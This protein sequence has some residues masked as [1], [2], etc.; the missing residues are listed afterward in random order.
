MRGMRILF[1]GVVLLAPAHAKR[2]LADAEALA[3][4]FPEATAFTAEE[5]TLSAEA[6]RDAARRLGSPVPEGPWTVHTAKKEN[7]TLGWAFFV[8]EIGKTMP[9]TLLVGVSADGR[10]AGV[11]LVEFRES[12]GDGIARTSFREQFKGKTLAD[13]LKISR[14]IRSVTSST[15][16]AE[17]T[18]LAVRK[19]LVLAEALRLNA[20]SQAGGSREYKKTAYQM[21][22]DVEVMLVTDDPAKA[23]FLF[24]QAFGIFTRVESQASHFL[25]ESDL[26]RLN[27]Q[28]GPW[29]TFPPTGRHAVPECLE[30]ARRWSEKTAG[31]FDVTAAPL[32]A[33]WGFGAWPGENRVPSEEEIRLALSHVGWEKVELRTEP[34]SQLHAPPWQA[35][36]PPGTQITLGGI[37]AG[38]AIDRVVEEFRARGVAQAVVNAGGDLYVL[39]GPVQEEAAWIG[40]RHPR[41]KSKLA[42]AV[43]LR[44][45]AIA[46]SGDAEKFFEADGKRYSHILDPRTG[47]PVPWQ[48]SVTVVAP[49][50][51]DADALS[52]ALYVLGPQQGTALVDALGPDYA[53]IFLEAR[54]DGTLHPSLTARMKPLY[55]EKN[56]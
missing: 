27:R 10:V 39:S 45:G 48:G 40:I 12:R 15:M 54:P 22:T 49:T 19:A 55:R 42:G 36:I 23:E 31:A 7:E 5:K 4:A 38:Y 28:A 20:P 9:I 3:K 2:Y 30:Q 56:K 24:E 41:D 32:V 6:A 26:S 35:R 44:D 13:P 16:S 21:G 53:A 52:T 11:E 37:A 34:D 14:D 51:T 17:A 18:C 1:A 33:L 29:F 50:A 8:D 47:R 25:P 46:T 43:H